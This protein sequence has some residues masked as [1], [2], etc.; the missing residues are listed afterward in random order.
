L[1]WTLLYCRS[2]TSFSWIKPDEEAYKAEYERSLLDGLLTQL[3]SIKLG[4]NIE[5]D[6]M[7]DRALIAHWILNKGSSEKVIELIQKD[8]KTY[9]QINDYK[10]LRVLFG[11]LLKEIQRIRSEG[12]F[13]TAQDLVENLGVKI[14]PILHEEIIQRD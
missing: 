13:K 9:L 2:K 4:D 14:D 8:K 7:R 1:F 11:E 12:D 6:H 10:K 5:E 3:K